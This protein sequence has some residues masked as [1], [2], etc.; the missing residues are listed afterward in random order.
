MSNKIVNQ[1]K[2]STK[3]LGMGLS[4]LLGEI[5]GNN[6]INFT[7]SELIEKIQDE[8]LKG[9]QMISTEKV[10][11]NINQPRKIFSENEL[12]ELSD[13]INKNGILQPI[14]VRE[15]GDKFEIVTGERRFRASK[16]AGLKEIP[17]IVKN[18]SDQQ[19]FLFAILENIQREDLNPLEEAE[20][21]A[22]LINDFAYTQDQISEI[23]HKSRSH[24][25]NLIRLIKLPEEVKIMVKEGKLTSGHVRP[26][27]ALKSIEQIISVAEVVYENKYSARK[28]EEL[29]NLI[30]SDEEKLE[31]NE[32]NK[33]ALKLPSKNHINLDL[34]EKLTKKFEAKFQSKINIKPSKKG[35][36]I[37]IKYKTEEELKNIMNSLMEEQEFILPDKKDNFLKF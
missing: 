30:L 29:V 10:I 2:S 1:K 27:L 28:V 33:K 13:S 18:I 16:L 3:R 14:L 24:I 4:A 7:E 20:S 12:L 22:K 23:V 26:L 15:K 19:I 31:E 5:D 11:P 37:S 32:N 35:G 25:A 8:S 21:Y 17:C 9:Y 34:I 36:S 6:Q